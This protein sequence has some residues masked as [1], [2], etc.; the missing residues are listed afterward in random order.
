[1]ALPRDK[2]QALLAPTI[3]DNAI[4]VERS[5][6]GFFCRYYSKKA[7]DSKKDRPSK[8]GRGIEK[9]HVELSSE[10]LNEVVDFDKMKQQMDLA[11]DHLK[12]EYAEQL[13]Q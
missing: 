9:P 5:L 7:K 1:M 10:E 2:Q 13:R 8:K 4:F 3:I 6:V 12:K 11:L